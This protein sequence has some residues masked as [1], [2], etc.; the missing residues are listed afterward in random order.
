MKFH[1]S[2]TSSLDGGELSASFRGC[3]SPGTAVPVTAGYEDG[4]TPQLFPTRCWGEKSL[5]VLGTD[6]GRVGPY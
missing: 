6:S 2:L 5:L 1:V 3:Y 4:W